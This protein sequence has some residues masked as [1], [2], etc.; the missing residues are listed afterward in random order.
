M[1]GQIEDAQKGDV[2]LKDDQTPVPEP[3]KEEKIVDLDDYMNEKGI[4]LSMTQ[5]GGNTEQLEDPKMFEDENTVAIVSKKK[6]VTDNKKK[7]DRDEVV[8]GGTVMTDKWKPQRRKRKKAKK[9]RLTEDDFP[10][11]S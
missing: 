10:A 8:L 1:E 3:P 6:T 2:T 7:Q 4:K 11:L 5:K 9:N